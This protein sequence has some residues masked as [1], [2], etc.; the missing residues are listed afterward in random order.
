MEVVVL[1]VHLHVDLLPCLSAPD[2]SS[3]VFADEYFCSHI[4]KFFQVMDMFQ[5][6]LI[7][8]DFE[9]IAS[10]MFNNDPKSQVENLKVSFWT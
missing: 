4:S 5:E 8:N 1:P 7:N 3:V 10:E 9:L 6:N 2:L